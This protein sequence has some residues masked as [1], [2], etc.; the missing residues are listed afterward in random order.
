MFLQAL[1]KLQVDP[2]VVSSCTGMSLPPGAT[3]YHYDPTKVLGQGQSMGGMYTNIIGAVE[4][5]IRAVVPTGAGGYWTYFMF[6]S[7]FG[8]VDSLQGLIAALLATADGLS[9]LHPAVQLIETAWEPSDPYVYTPRL[10]RRPLDG[11][12]V[13]SIYETM[14][15]GDSYFTPEVYDEMAMAY[16]HPEAGDAIWTSMQDALKLV[17]LDGLRSYPIKGDVSSEGGAKY[18][19]IAVQ[20]A[21]D[22]VY[23]PHAIYSQLDSVKYQYGCFFESFLR[24]GVATVPPVAASGTPCP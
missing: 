6:H 11:H 7:H 16:G 3:T 13:R 19:G 1:L 10:A 20:Y 21:G 2:S 8:G 9:F 12:P 14:A 18:T 17:G 22:G 15:L 23:D 5:K 4:P 24:D